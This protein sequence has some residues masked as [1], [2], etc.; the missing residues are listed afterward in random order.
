MKLLLTQS[1]VSEVETHST[2]FE[3]GSRESTKGKADPLRGRQPKA[4]TATS[5][6]PG[7]CLAFDGLAEGDLAAC[8]GYLLGVDAEDPEHADTKRVGD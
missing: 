2:G 1:N 3:G 4:K 5:G 6:L 7:N 8:F